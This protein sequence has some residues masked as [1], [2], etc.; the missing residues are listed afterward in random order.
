MTTEKNAAGSPHAAD[1]AWKAYI[2][3]TGTVLVAIMLQPGIDWIRWGYPLLTLP[4]AIVGASGLGILDGLFL[5]RKNAF[6]QKNLEYGVYASG[7]SVLAEAAYVIMLH[8][9]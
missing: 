5:S 1:R 9:C 2:I 7:A 8:H 6:Y 3:A 4:C